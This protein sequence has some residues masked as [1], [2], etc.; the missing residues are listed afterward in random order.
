M[1]DAYHIN[2]TWGHKE[3]GQLKLYEGGKP[4]SGQPSFS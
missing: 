4:E 2:K 3:V 1:H